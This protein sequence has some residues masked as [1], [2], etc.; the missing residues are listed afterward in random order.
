ML[1]HTELFSNVSGLGLIH[2]GLGLEKF[3]GPHPRPLFLASASCPAGLVNIPA[4]T[5]SHQWGRIRIHTDNKVHCMGAYPLYGALSQR[6]LLD[7]I[8]PAYNQ[9]WPDGWLKLT[10]SVFNLQPTVSSTDYV[11]QNASSPGHSTYYYAELT[12]SF[13]NTH[14]PV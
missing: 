10:A 5:H 4:F 3:F 13:I 12:A 14:T 11:D 6:G 8:K 2:C 1:T 9:S 7:P